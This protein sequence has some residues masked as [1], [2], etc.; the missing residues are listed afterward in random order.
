S[1][2]RKLALILRPRPK[3]RGLHGKTRKRKILEGSRN[4]RAVNR[5][6][7]RFAFSETGSAH[8]SRF[9]VRRN[10][11]LLLIFRHYFEILND[12]VDVPRRLFIPFVE[13][14]HCRVEANGGG[15]G[16]PTPQPPV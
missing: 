10:S 3:R 11:G 1:H 5:E 9:A 4:P 16:N 12:V 8:R 6:R 7:N 13:W 15:I 14:R 2:P